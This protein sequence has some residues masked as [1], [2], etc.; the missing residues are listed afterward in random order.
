MKANMSLGDR[1]DRFGGKLVYR[2]AGLA[3]SIMALGLGSGLWWA[4]KAGDVTAMIVF[5]PLLIGAGRGEFNRQ[6]PAPSHR[7]S[8]AYPRC[9]KRGG[10][11]GRGY[12]IVADRRPEP[13]NNS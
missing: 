6:A 12:R 4:V 10:S 1:I 13:R 9:R 2:F 8:R 3:V 5:T 11:C 7:S